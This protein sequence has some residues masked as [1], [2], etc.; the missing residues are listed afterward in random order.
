MRLLSESPEWRLAGVAE[1]DAHV[2]AGL[3][4]QGIPVLPRQTLLE[5]PG[6]RVIV[7]ESGLSDR[8]RHARDVLRAGKHVH[9]EKPPAAGLR[10]LEEV[11]E[12]ARS[13][14]LRL[15]VGYMWRYHPG[16]ARVFQAVREGW[17]GQVYLIRA[18]ISNQLAPRR[19]P[20]WAGYPGGVMF[21]LGCHLVDGMV[22]LMGPPR[23]IASFLRHHGP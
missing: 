2:A 5:D 11:V 22:R 19:R 6:I 18:N 13:R 20:E 7:V 4:Q 8:A 23:R 9:V 12:L 15:Q 16:F 10:E 14:G 17:L 21:E 1:E 3:R